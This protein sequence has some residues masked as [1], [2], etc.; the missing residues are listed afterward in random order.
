MGE[1]KFGKMDIPLVVSWLLLIFIGWVN[2]F[3]SIYSEEH[4]SI[5]DMSQRLEQ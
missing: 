3:A 5:F 2:I 1:Y 4:S